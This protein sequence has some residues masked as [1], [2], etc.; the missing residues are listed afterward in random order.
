MSYINVS[1]STGLIKWMNDE[2]VSATTNSSNMLA[3]SSSKVFVRL[4]QA[5]GL[6]FAHPCPRHMSHLIELQYLY[7]QSKTLVLV[8]I[9]PRGS[10][11]YY[12]PLNECFLLKHFVLV[13][14]SKSTSALKYKI[15][16]DTWLDITQLLRIHWA[17]VSQYL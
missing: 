15:Y 2:Y 11:S 8:I 14:R 3:W 5:H 16:N 1:W 6:V 10:N 9:C 7:F 13:V 4:D 17:G 12:T